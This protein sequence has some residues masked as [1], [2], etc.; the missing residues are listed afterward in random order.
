MCSL[1]PEEVEKSPKQDELWSSV[2]SEDGGADKHSQHSEFKGEILF[3][4]LSEGHL[5]NTLW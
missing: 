2:Y 5:E 4:Y 1:P 3:C